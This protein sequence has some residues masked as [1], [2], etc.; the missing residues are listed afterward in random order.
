MSDLNKFTMNITLELDVSFHKQG[1]SMRVFRR[2]A[3]I[4]LL[5]SLAACGTEE[6]TTPTDK[7][8]GEEQISKQDSSISS[9]SVIAAADLEQLQERFAKL[10]IDVMKASDTPI[11]GLYELTTNAGVLYSTLEGD[12]FFTGTLFSLDTDGN[13]V[14]LLAAKQ[15]PMNAEKV[16]SFSDD[17]IVYKAENEKH[18]IT[19]FTDIT[20]GYCLKLHREL[21]DYLGEGI[22]VRYLAYPRNGLQNQ[23]AE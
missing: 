20:C 11:E 23:T 14:D 1:N 13:Y 10:R 9:E 22:T 18:V 15:Q 17:M 19:V 2:F 8:T 4:S 21:E 5:V 6:P 7:A 3:L 16:E 12:H